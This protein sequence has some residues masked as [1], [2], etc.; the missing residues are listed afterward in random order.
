[1]V[2]LTY[3]GNACFHLSL[4]GVSI[5]VDPYLEDNGEWSGGLDSAL[6]TVGPVDVVCVTHLATDHVGDTLELARE[7]ELPVVTEPAVTEY[8]TRNGTPGTRVTQLVWGLEARVDEVSIRAL[9]VD[10]ASTGRVD[11]QFVS[12]QALSFL[13]RYRDRTVYHGGD[14]SLFGDLREY[15]ERYDVDVAMLG[16]GQAFEEPPSPD[17]V[18][19][20]TRE[21][22]TEE[23]V[24]AAVRVDPAVVVPMHY[25]GD[26][27]TEFERSAAKSGAFIGSV[28][29]M[30]PG[31]TKLFLTE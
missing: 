17:G 3:F 5:L 31:E 1:M 8:L 15:G 21:V 11:G 12:G 26:E 19:R 29:P 24:E 9:K 22:T 6:D 16:V 2:E 20:M 7:Y 28:E 25:V 27:R 30:D 4:G 18:E 14:T 10:H 23:A 13:F